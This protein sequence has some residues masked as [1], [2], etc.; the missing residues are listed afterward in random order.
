MHIHDDPDDLLNTI[1]LWSCRCARYPA[2]SFTS[3]KITLQKSLLRL[4]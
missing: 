4:D 3:L 2:R 1:Q